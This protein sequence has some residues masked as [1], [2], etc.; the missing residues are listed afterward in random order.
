MAGKIAESAGDSTKY[1]LIWSWLAGKWKCLTSETRYQLFL[2]LNA[3]V[4]VVACTIYATEMQCSKWTLKFRHEGSSEYKRLK[5][6]M[7]HN[8]HFAFVLVDVCKVYYI[9]R[10]Y[11]QTDVHKH[12]PANVIFFLN[13]LYKRALKQMC[14]PISVHPP[15][16]CHQTGTKIRYWL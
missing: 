14:G 9:F 15:R 6:L 5:T 7:A 11:A 3:I 8:R 4:I 1:Q 16:A 2:C 10:S 13:G 12:T